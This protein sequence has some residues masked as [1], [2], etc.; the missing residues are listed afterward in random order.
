MRWRTLVLVL[1]LVVLAIPVVGV[2]GLWAIDAGYWR[3]VISRHV[4]A[5]TG[6]KLEIA[7]P[8]TIDWG[9]RT[10]IALEGLKLANA[11]WAAAPTMLE[12]PRLELQARLM[13][14]LG[15]RP[16]IERLSLIG[17]ALELETA[18]DDR[19]SWDLATVPPATPPTPSDG[20]ASAIV[21]EVTIENG[22]IRYVSDGSGPVTT[23]K[24]A[25]GVL[26]GDASGASAAIDVNGDLDGVA[27]GLS[28]RLAQPSAVL[29]GTLGEAA[30]TDLKVRLGDDELA[31]T[32]TVNWAGERVH[33]RA[34]LAGE[35]LDPTPFLA[36]GGNR[37]GAAEKSNSTSALDGLTAIDAEVGLRAGTLALRELEVTK[38]EA[39]G[40]LKAGRLELSPLRLELDGRPVTGSLVLDGGKQPNEA[41]FKA[42]ADG[43]AV[44]PVLAGLGLPALIEGPADVRA[45]LRGHGASPKEWAA[46]SDG[47]V[48]LIMN[49]GQMG[50]RL[51]DQLAGGLR[52]LA[53][54]LGRAR[55]GEGHR[56]PL[57]GARC[58]VRG[59]RRP[60]R[61]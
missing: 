30:L 16:E 2:A 9:W 8:L 55:G 58:A 51:V 46:T 32:A 10:T 12:V 13:S 36:L 33:L 27:A 11:P 29:L 24:V 21:R 42:A 35:R 5:A 17:P 50:D 48:R 40:K 57:R 38:V 14:L 47:H 25:R 23:I 59:R 4:E 18:A 39:E 7:G 20:A 28:G 37:Q 45:E 34:D 41:S 60:A 19:Q 6:R 3:G 49:G 22:T 56:D 1:L 53:G 15:G 61:T 52:Q 26:T 43:L 31:G 44:G 54:S